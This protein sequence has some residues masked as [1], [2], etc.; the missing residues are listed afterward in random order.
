MMNKLT[1]LVHWN[2]AEDPTQP[3]LYFVASR[4]KTGF[5]SYDFIEWNG[6]EWLKAESINIIGWVAI[7]DFLK[8]IEAGWPASDN[9]D[10]DEF[11]AYDKKRVKNTFADDFVEVE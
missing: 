6:E 11:V 9:L 4:D 1:S 8:N 3:G 5:G 10:D 2:E 7:G